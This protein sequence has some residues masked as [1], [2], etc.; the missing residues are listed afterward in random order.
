MHPGGLTGALPCLALSLPLPFLTD[1]LQ[2][3]LANR[4]F[5]DKAPAKVVEEVQAAAQQARE[6]LAAVQDKIAKFSQFL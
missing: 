6:Q 4:S 3:R 2:A 1:L 5:V